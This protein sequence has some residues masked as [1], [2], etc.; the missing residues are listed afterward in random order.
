M[1]NYFTL[2]S[3][4]INLDNIYLNP[5]LFQNSIGDIK[6]PSNLQD[7][8]VRHT[9]LETKYQLEKL[10]G[11]GWEPGFSKLKRSLTT[12]EDIEMQQGENSAKRVQH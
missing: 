7:L 10:K 3:F 1:H 11:E 8:R 5:T 4:L 2:I 12:D 6:L 9:T